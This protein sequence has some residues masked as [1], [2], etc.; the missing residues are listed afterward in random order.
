MFSILILFTGFAWFIYT[1]LA[2]IQP[3]SNTIGI[4]PVIFTGDRYETDINTL[5]T[6]TLPYAA[7]I[8]LVLLAGP[9]LRFLR[10]Y[11]YARVIRE[12]GIQKIHAKW[13]VFV[14]K[15]ASQL[16]IKKTVH[17]WISEFVSTPVTVGF[18]KPVILIPI[19]ALNN[20]S[21]QQLEAVILHELAHIRRFDYLLN[22]ILNIIRTFLY[23]NPFVKAFI[24]IVETER[25]KSCDE[26]VLQF[27]YNSYEYASALLTL[28]KGTETSPILL[29]ASGGNKNNLLERVEII[30][31]VQKK[32]IFRFNKLPACI[33]GLLCFIIF[34]CSLLIKHS[35]STKNSAP[36]SQ[37]VSFYTFPKAAIIPTMD[38]NLN[39]VQ[40][41]VKSPVLPDEFSQN[42]KLGAS[43]KQGSGEIL[44]DFVTNNR[45]NSSGLISSLEPV[46]FETTV[47][48]ELKEYQEAQVQKALDD[49]RRVI[50]S[51]QWEMLESKMADVLTE[52]EKEELK[53][54]YQEEIQKF[55]WQ[56]WENRLKLVYNNVDWE[57]VNYQLTNAVNQIRLDSLQKVYTS[58]VVKLNDMNKELTRK[59]L[60]SI[61][62]T[63]ITL[64]E[65]ENKKNEAM[66]AV[67]ELRNNKNKKV[68]RL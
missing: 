66:K 44:S 32:S 68:V 10:S 3:G 2:A 18:L 31:G 8:Y 39:P 41:K 60:K 47:T 6:K 26:T 54:A 65:I 50:A 48:P 58:I 61:P 23:F 5:V 17:I 55:D 38:I 21:T 16:G 52:K 45:I 22:L 67:I 64:K 33:V 27:Q 13:R 12:Q 15:V 29:M 56:K 24:K 7:I 53:S 11:R 1:F 57:K 49:S 9:V 37:A 4:S 63:D 46:A 62:D 43:I 35:T 20:L 51:M 59:N 19:A 30:M 34:N 40:D 25:E 42:K 14:K 36:P 28:E